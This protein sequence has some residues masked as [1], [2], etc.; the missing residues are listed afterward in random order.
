MSTTDNSPISDGAA[1]LA[2]G[3]ELQSNVR[4]LLMQLPPERLQA[5]A[6]FAAYLASA[7]GETAAQELMA[8]PGLLERV[9]RNQE[10]SNE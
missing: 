1:E 5:L 6:D 3:T 9:K 4:D 10:P 7:E 2:A 8:I